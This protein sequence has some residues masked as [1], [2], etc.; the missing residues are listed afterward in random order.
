MLL[1]AVSCMD[2][3]RVNRSNTTELVVDTTEFVVTSASQILSVDYSGPDGGTLKATVDATASDWLTAVL[4][5]DSITLIVTENTTGASRSGTVTLS[6]SG[7]ENVTLTVTQLYTVITVNSDVTVY[8]NG[9]TITVPYSVSGSVSETSLTAT[10]DATSTS[11]LSAVV[12]DNAVTLT[13]TENISKADRSGIVTLSTPGASDVSFTVNQVVPVINVASSQISLLYTEGTETIEFSVSNAVDGEVVT[14]IVSGTAVTSAS[15]NN[16]T[17]TLTKSENTGTSKRT[18]TVTLSSTYA[19]SVELSVE[20]GTSYTA[21]LGT[22]VVTDEQNTSATITIS[23][24][25]ENQ[26]YT[27]SGWQFG[28]VLTFDDLGIVGSGGTTDFTAPYNADTKSLEIE[29][30]ALGTGT[31]SVYTDISGTLYVLGSVFLPGESTSGGYTVIA[32]DNL[33]LATMTVSDDGSTATLT[34]G[35]IYAN[36][37]QED[38]SEQ[39]I[40]QIQ[41]VLINE[42]S[43][44][45]ILWEP[46]YGTYLPSSLTR[47]ST[48]TASTSANRSGQYVVA[49][50]SEAQVVK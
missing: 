17:L 2:A 12:G 8:A 48:S 11:W 42:D 6:Y 32:R 39:T 41:F 22:W 19:Q 21:F 40:S 18:G 9:G 29:V 31:H 20:Q 27:I 47:V 23:Q 7:G 33:T 30:T 28:E 44:A 4:G 16:S 1:A 14:A 43:G 3:I 5:Y 46:K 37:S 26:S 25:V 15:V 36:F 45:S 49:A 10:V 50:K 34:G 13:V 38:Y 35:T 24:K